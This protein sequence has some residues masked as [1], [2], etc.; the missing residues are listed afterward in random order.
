MV[1]DL[2]GKRVANIS[3]AP[4]EADLGQLSEGEHT[5]DLKVYLSRINTFGA[6]H[7]SNY[8]H[9]WF[10]PDGWYSEDEHWSYE[11]RITPDGLLTAPRIF[12]K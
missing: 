9:T 10:G 8:S 5:L 6:L 1:A 2:D 7:L 11:Y 4:Y 3:L 12:T